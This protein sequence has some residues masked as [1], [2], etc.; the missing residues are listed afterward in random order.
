MTCNLQHLIHETQK[1]ITRNSRKFSYLK[2]NHNNIYLKNQ[3]IFSLK[4]NNFL[5]HQCWHAKDM[6]PRC[7]NMN[8]TQ[9]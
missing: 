5:T 7:C 6:N 3:E 9:T 2:K 8:I 4:E 1:I